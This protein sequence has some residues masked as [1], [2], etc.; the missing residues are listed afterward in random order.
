MKSIAFPSKLK[1]NF[2]EFMKK[3]VFKKVH[4][5]N[6][7]GLSKPNIMKTFLPHEKKITLIT[8][9]PNYNTYLINVKHSSIER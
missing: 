3:K 5:T 4:I 2:V 7:Q 9:F 8:R 1:T 6:L